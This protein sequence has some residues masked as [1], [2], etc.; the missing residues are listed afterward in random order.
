M[1][2]SR[3]SS[4][5]VDVSVCMYVCMVFFSFSVSAPALLSVDSNFI[6]S[7]L[8]IFLCASSINCIFSL[9]KIFL[10]KQH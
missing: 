6:H 5:I 9:Y 8:C 1:I 3:G 2:R 7:I 4:A 10:Y